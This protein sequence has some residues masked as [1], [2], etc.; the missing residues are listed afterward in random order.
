[1]N[2]ALLFLLIVAT[3]SMSLVAADDSRDYGGNRYG[4]GDGG[5]YGGSYDGSYGG[6]YGN[7]GGYSG[8]HRAGLGGY[9]YW[10]TER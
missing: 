8:G 2:K 4:V 5:N 1:M 9:G 3:L 10:F 6:N 7:H